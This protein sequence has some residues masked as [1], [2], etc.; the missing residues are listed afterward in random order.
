MVK[1]ERNCTSMN[2]DC[3]TSFIA[4]GS[5]NI[6]ARHIKTV[7]RSAG[8]VRLSSESAINGQAHCL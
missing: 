2:D 8:P 6:P 3:P 4:F 7:K 5:L 1:D